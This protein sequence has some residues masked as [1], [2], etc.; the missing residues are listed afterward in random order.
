VG[1]LAVLPSHEEGEARGITASR[2][3]SEETLFGSIHAPAQEGRLGK[4]PRENRPS[5]QVVGHR[6]VPD[7]CGHAQGH[8]EY[9]AQQVAFHLP[10][11]L[12]AG[13]GH[14]VGSGEL[15]I[16]LVDFPGFAGDGFAVGRGDLKGHLLHAQF[17]VDGHRDSGPE[18]HVGLVENRSLL[19]FGPRPDLL[20]RPPLRC[21][22]CALLS[23]TASVSSVTA[24]SRV[25]KFGV[26]FLEIG[27]LVVK[28]G[29]VDIPHQ[30]Y[31]PGILDD[32]A[33][34]D[35]VGGDRP[36]LPIVRTLV[37]GG[38]GHEIE[39]L[40]QVQWHRIGEIHIVVVQDRAAHG[41]QV[42]NQ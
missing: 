21:R 20:L 41:H 29:E 32:V 31:I 36:G 33:Q 42:G 13:R 28:R 7:P 24:P 35:G 37:T 8:I 15:H 11:D 19:F 2:G 17:V 39:S 14:A 16:V 27:D 30:A 10:G 23:H 38:G 4:V 1:E 22:R 6:Q 9:L 5:G 25:L 40:D 12:D 34:P 3:G 26:Q 18:G